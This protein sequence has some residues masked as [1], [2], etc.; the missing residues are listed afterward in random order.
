MLLTYPNLV[1]VSVLQDSNKVTWW[2]FLWSLILA[3]SKLSAESQQP[4]NMLVAS[5]GYL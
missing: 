4:M 3:C 1:T 5:A 2:K